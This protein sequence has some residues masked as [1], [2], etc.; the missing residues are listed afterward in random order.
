[1]SNNNWKQKVLTPILLKESD[2]S[3][4]TVQDLQN[5]IKNDDILNIA[6]TGPYGSGKSSVL[7]T[8]QNEA[9]SDIK[10]LDIS[11]A[12]LDAD[13]SLADNSKEKYQPNNFEEGKLLQEQKEVLNRKIEY[14]ILQ[15]LVYRKT[16]EE[17]PYSRMKKIRHFGEDT[18]RTIA[19]YSIGFIICMAFAFKLPLLQIP[20]LYRAF[21]IPNNL[22]DA[23]SIISVI[24]IIM[25]SI[26]M[27]RYVIRNFAGLRLQKVSVGGNEID[28]YDDGS[29][30]NRY[31]EEI[32]YFFQCTDYNVVIIEDLDRFNTTDIFLKLRELNHIINKSEMVGRTVKFIYAVK[33]DMFKDSSRSKFFDYITTVI[34]VITTTNSKDKLKEALEELGHKDE[35][36]DEDIRDI[37][38]HID[39]M[40]LLYNIANEY[41]QY[42]QRLSKEEHPLNSSKMLAMMTVKNYHPHDFSELHN[43]KGKLYEALSQKAKRKYVEFAINSRIAK[44]EELAKTNIEAYDAS[45]H[46]SVKELRLVYL[47]ALKSKVG[48][49]FDIFIID[50]HNYSISQIADNDALFEVIRKG[51]VI[52][53]KYYDSNYVRQREESINYSFSEIEKSVNSS[54]TYAKRASLIEADRHILE[55]ELLEVERE[56]DRVSSYKIHELIEKFNIY[57]EEFFKNIGLSP[58]EEDLIRRGYISEDYNDYITYFYPG[59]M[60]MADHLLCLDMKLDRKTEFD[61][62]IDNVELFLQELPPSALHYA[63]SWNYCILDYLSEHKALEKVRYN[64]A[65]DTLMKRDSAHFLYCYNINSER[66][67][68]VFADC[69]KRDSGQIWKKIIQTSDNEKAELFKLWFTICAVSDIH[70]L[71]KEWIKHNYVFMESIFEYLTDDIQELLTTKMNYDTLSL[72]DSDMLKRVVSNGCYV[73]NEN[74]ISVVVEVKDA[75]RDISNLGD[76]EEMQYALKLDLINATWY[77][78]NKYYSANGYT[79]DDCLIQ[80]IARHIQTLVS[81]SSNQGDEYSDLFQS[82]LEL[83]TFTDSTYI[84]ICEVSTCYVSVNESILGLSHAKLNILIETRTLEYSQTTFISLNKLSPAIGCAYMVTY[85]DKLDEMLQAGVMNTALAEHLLKNGKLNQTEYQ[86]II[87]SLNTSNISMSQYLANRICEILSL[88]YCACND[89]ILYDAIAMCS[90]ESHAVMTAVQKMNVSRMDVSTINGLLGVLPEKYHDLKEL[91]KKPKFEENNHN[92]ILIDALKKVNYIS[93]YKVENGKIKVETKHK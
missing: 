7:R 18:I 4:S 91:Y 10:I 87:A 3:Y 82:L 50:G 49:T 73:C 71:Q 85:R 80:Y 26:E 90:N 59:I 47:L 52:S 78:V 17:L 9:N 23:I 76:L 42:S 64:F 41:H 86:K 93:S 1:M 2:D 60:S 92:K 34:P 6:V 45:C 30:F 5:A 29:I 33:D 81:D 69:M 37:A 65:L 75:K 72:S 84:K 25:M 21:G 11:L 54:Y 79:V 39:D 77:N 31:L 89:D 44:R 53:Y 28:V 14:S 20:L 58:L 55:S 83:N 24:F 12:T 15:Q 38:F 48:R 43:R 22:Q 8:F 68:Y 67:K 35:V 36:P 74:N 13:E 62:P 16:L 70:E 57:D 51:S 63:S 88:Q 40:R 66:A 56:K 61:A 19:G 27:L 32:L 46:L